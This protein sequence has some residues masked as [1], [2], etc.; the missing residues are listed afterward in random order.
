M[1]KRS[2]LMGAVSFFALARCLNHH[3]HPWCIGK[4]G[5]LLH[6][7]LIQCYLASKRHVLY[8]LGVG[9]KARSLDAR[10]KVSLTLS[11]V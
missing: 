5:I 7:Y 1:F 9:I 6:C 4:R 11:A 3:A 10:Y 8:Y 2:W